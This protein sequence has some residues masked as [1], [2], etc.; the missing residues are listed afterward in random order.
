MDAMITPLPENR[1]LS[2]TFGMPT[3]PRPESKSSIIATATDVTGEF[4]FTARA[5]STI[6]LWRSDESMDDG[7]AQ[8]TFDTPHA[9]GA[10]TK[11]ACAPPQHLPASFASA[12]RDGLVVVYTLS[13][14]RR[15]LS[16]KTVVNASRDDA[17]QTTMLSSAPVLDL[18]FAPDGMLATLSPGVVRLYSRDEDVDL[19]EGCGGI[20][21]LQRAVDVDQNVGT[22]L[23]FA[24]GGMFLF[25]NGTVFARGRAPWVWEE[26]V[27]LPDLESNIGF[28]MG[29]G[30][31]R[32]V[33]A[34]W[35]ATGF[36]AVSRSE[37]ER[38][39]GVM[40]VYRLRNGVFTEVG[41]VE[42][43]HVVKEVEWDA[44]GTVFAGWTE[45]REIFKFGRTYMDGA[46]VWGIRDV[47]QLTM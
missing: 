44:T 3:T 17:G 9:P 27:R 13:P 43:E 29:F 47:M 32:L 25:A 20:W 26:A 36:I 30:S 10:I 28:G 41:K 4:L 23:C 42:M 8:A 35:G 5:D 37:G 11:V 14:C 21:R 45:A 38:D 1:R 31:G 2:S 40:E 15:L 16:S 12:G 6:A 34:H 46:W 7:T 33:A 22:A 18:T 39:A 24:P 19:T